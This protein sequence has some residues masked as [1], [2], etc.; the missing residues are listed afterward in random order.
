MYSRS[1]FSILSL[2]IKRMCTDVVMIELT[3]MKYLS[4]RSTRW[5][6]F[7]KTN[8]VTRIQ[9]DH[10]ASRQMLEIVK[11]LIH[12]HLSSSDVQ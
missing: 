11:S 9:S 7:E 1:K 2:P 12:E 10:I 8:I 3:L 5:R 4:T 6:S